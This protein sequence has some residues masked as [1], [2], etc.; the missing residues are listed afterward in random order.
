[1]LNT[2]L[3]ARRKG[4]PKIEERLDG[5]EGFFTR[6]IFSEPRSVIDKLV[7]LFLGVSQPATISEKQIQLLGQTYIRLKRIP[8]Q[9]GYRKAPK[10]VERESPAMETLSQLS[11]QDPT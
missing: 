5:R 4:G 8:G 11:N 3:D 6:N 9:H 1:M 7:T 10:Y 2:N